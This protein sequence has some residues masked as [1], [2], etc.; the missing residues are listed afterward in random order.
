[1]SEFE[2]LAQPPAGT[3]DRK[4]FRRGATL[5]LLIASTVLVAWTAARATRQEPLES[6]SSAKLIDDPKDRVS[7]QH[8]VIGT[9]ATGNQPGD[10]AIIVQSDGTVLFQLVGALEKTLKYSDTYR[11][12]MIGDNPCLITA[13]NGTIAT[14]DID[15]LSFCDD[16]YQRTK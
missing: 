12:G 13:H 4:L 5:L 11:L 15:H 7:R 14:T 3:R 2:A 10:R 16:T 8:D 6:A 9:F 1:M